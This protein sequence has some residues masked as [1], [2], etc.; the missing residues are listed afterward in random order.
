MKK[1]LLSIISLLIITLP[2]S[3]LASSSQAEVYRWKDKDGKVHFGDKKPDATAENITKKVS[4]QNIDT[5]TQ[6]L[7]KMETIFRKEND[8][9]RAHQ[10]QLNEASQ[11]Q[12]QRCEQ[13]HLQLKRF[14]GRVQYIDADG[15]PVKVTETEHKQRIAEMRDAIAQYCG[16]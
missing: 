12:E 10:Q 5:S 1:H 2:S 13:A 14:E 15:K 7:R 9:D 3:F 4:T 6:E 8:A 11:E 16:E